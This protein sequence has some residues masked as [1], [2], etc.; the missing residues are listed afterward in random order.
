MKASQMQIVGASIFI[1]SCIQEIKQNY[2]FISIAWP[3]HKN[4]VLLIQNSYFLNFFIRVTFCKII[5]IFFFF[6]LT[7]THGNIVFFKMS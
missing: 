3:H 6:K 2:Q 4:G 7:L 1:S 5:H